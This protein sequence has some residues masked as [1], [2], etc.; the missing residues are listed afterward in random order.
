[1]LYHHK[2]EVLEAP[3]LPVDNDSPTAVG[4]FLILRIISLHDF[5][6]ITLKDITSPV[7]LFRTPFYSPVPYK[8]GGWGR[9]VF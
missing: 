5:K 9:D 1:M 3:L 6:E 2:F 4:Y 7:R 8:S